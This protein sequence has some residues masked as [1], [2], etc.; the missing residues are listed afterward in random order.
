MVWR[1][2]IRNEFLYYFILH[3]PFRIFASKILVMTSQKVYLFAPENDL[4]LATNKRYYTPPPAARKIAADLSLLPLWYADDNSL[5]LSQQAIPSDLQRVIENLG[6]CSQAVSSL[7]P[8]EW[9]CYPWGWSTYICQQLEKAGIEKHLLPDNQQI[10]EIRRLSGRATTRDI[11]QHIASILPNLPLPPAPE[12]LYDAAEIKHFIETHHATLL[13]APWS[14]SGR[15]IIR[16][17]GTYNFSIARQA[18]GILRKQGYIMGEILFDKI[19]DL[20]FEFHSDGIQTQFTGYSLFNTDLHGCYTHNILASDTAIERH[21]SHLIPIDT[22]HNVRD[23]L[24][25]ITSQ[26]IAPHYKGYFGIDSILYRNNTDIC[27]HPCIELNLRMNMGIVAHHINR[28]YVAEGSSGSYHVVYEKSPLRH[29]ERQ[30]ALQKKYPMIIKDKRI[31]AG[32][33]PLTPLYDD[34]SYQAYIIIE[35][36]NFL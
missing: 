31:I 10:V 25:L 32:F 24:R 8:G 13:K 26:L 28:Y 11:W 14:S 21:L 2:N 20:A 4:A 9:D 36:K 18:E 27:L 30:Q 6:I 12:I 34:T 7:P 16:T 29:R 35:E 15:G 33:I 3:S 22:L 19:V 17:N 1:K 23:T 5:V